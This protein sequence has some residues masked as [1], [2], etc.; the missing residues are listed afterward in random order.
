MASIGPNI[1]FP[2]SIREY[3]EID[4]VERIYEVVKEVINTLKGIS[5]NS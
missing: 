3:V 5:K 1:R 2:H 4:S